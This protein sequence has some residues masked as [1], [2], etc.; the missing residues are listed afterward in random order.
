MPKKYR[1]ATASRKV[2]KAT[3]AI[4]SDR[5]PGSPTPEDLKGL[6]GIDMDLARTLANYGS[7]E[8]GSNKPPSRSVAEMAEPFELEALRVREVTM[9]LDIGAARAF[10]DACMNS[11]P[12]VTYGPRPG[13][14]VPFHGATPGRD[15]RT[16]D[17]SGFVREA[18]WRATNPRLNFKD[19]S[20]V[21]H[22]WIRTQGF[23]K[24]TPEA[25]M[26]HD[27]VVRIAFLRPQNSPSRIGHVALVHNGQTLE[28]HGGVGPDSRTWT[29]SGWQ[30]KAFV[31][32]LTKPAV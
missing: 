12:R 3:A 13:A 21:Q 20:V 24:G 16:V 27:G 29:K 26:L 5:D 31:Y 22:D 10:L 19:G 1:K 6:V 15:F 28:S 17:C 14:K 25:A 7:V 30:A 23:T 4:K 8:P 2:R 11:S 32:V 9:P 18:I